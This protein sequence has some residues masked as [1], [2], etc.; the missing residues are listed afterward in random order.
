MGSESKRRTSL[1]VSEDCGVVGGVDERNIQRTVGESMMT[2]MM[3]MMALMT[4]E[5]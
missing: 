1:V 4:T 3:T 5:V 2:M